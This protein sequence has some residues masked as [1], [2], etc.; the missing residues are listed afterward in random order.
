M[1]RRRL[2]ND[3]QT[4]DE[5]TSASSRRVRYSSRSGVRGAKG[6]E[7]T[8]EP[9]VFGRLTTQTEGVPPTDRQGLSPRSTKWLPTFEAWLRVAQSCERGTGRLIP[10]RLSQL[11]RGI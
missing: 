3:N 6:R 4:G 2:R 11:P 8:R 5:P 9:A 7:R 10:P 1:T